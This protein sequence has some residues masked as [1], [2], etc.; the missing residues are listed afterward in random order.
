MKNLKANKGLKTSMLAT[1]LFSALFGLTQTAQAADTRQVD[2][3]GW[4]KSGDAI[5][6]TISADALA[7]NEANLIFIRPLD[8]DGLQTSANISVDGRFQVSLQPGHYSQVV[9]CSGQHNITVMPT[10]A[11]TNDLSKTSATT[12]IELAPQRNHY[13]YV[14][15]DDNTAQPKLSLLETDYAQN[16]LA[17]QKQQV[18]QIS[19]VVRDCPAVVVQPEPEP[20]P[21][22][23]KVEIDKPINLEVLF[24]FDKAVVQPMFNARIEAVANFMK[25][26]PN[27]STI[28]EGHTDSIGSDSYNMDLSKRR[29]EAVKQEL[30]TMYGIDPNRLQTQGFGETRPVD[31]N[32]TPEG[33][34]NNRRVVATVSATK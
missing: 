26:Y 14:D 31:T 7:E 15:I 23:V 29:A 27:T 21:E 9:Y 34:Y 18:H 11:K 33:R 24:E 10:G 5:F 1:A 22:P 2:L 4:Q 25:K 16:L 28:I 17:D 32:A 30:V 3:I 6:K 12:P 19:R 8:N 20:Q 13:I